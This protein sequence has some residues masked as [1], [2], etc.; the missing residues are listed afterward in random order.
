[1]KYIVKEILF[2]RKEIVRGA[3]V[4]VVTGERST[5][6]RRPIDLL[7]PLEVQGWVLFVF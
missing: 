6:L 5:E 1:L 4:T 7:Y 2:G 3:I